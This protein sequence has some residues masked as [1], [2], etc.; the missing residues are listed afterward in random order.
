MRVP[1]AKAEYLHLPQD[2]LLGLLCLTDAM[3]L[4]LYSYWAEEQSIGRVRGTPYSES[5]PLRDFIRDQWDR[6]GRT[7]RD[8]QEREREMVKGMIGLM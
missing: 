6:F 5:Q 2:Q 3:L 1:S 8:D 4:F 7:L